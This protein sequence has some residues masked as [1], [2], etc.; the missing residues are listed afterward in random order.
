MEVGGLFWTVKNLWSGHLSKREGIRYPGRI[1][2]GQVAQIVVTI[3]GIVFAVAFIFKWG[4]RIDE[5]RQALGSSY[6]QLEVEKISNEDWAT[7][8][9]DE[10]IVT[11][12][13]KT[14]L[15]TIPERWYAV[16]ISVVL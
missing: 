12:D 13:E 8:T 9:L 7:I 4:E 16:A 1:W 2:V 14:A 3:V 6:T 10:L 5:E 15:E 11:E